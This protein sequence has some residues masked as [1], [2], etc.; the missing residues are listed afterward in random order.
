MPFHR[1]EREDLLLDLKIQ[2]RASSDQIIGAVADP[3]S[4]WGE[5]LK[6]RITAPPVEGRANDHLIRLLAKQFGVPR[7]KITLEGG[8]SSRDKRVRVREPERL[9]VEFGRLEKGVV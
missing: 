9:P 2:P 1:W 6:L 3:S 4:R 8:K 7:S 5:R